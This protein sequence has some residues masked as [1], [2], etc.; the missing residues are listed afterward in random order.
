MTSQPWPEKLPAQSVRIARPT[1]RLDDVVRFYTRRA[2]AA[3]AR[4]FRRSCRLPGRAAGVARLGTTW[5]SPSMITAARAGA[6][7]DNLLV[8]YFGDLAQVGQVARRLAALGHLPVEAEN[9]YWT[10]NGAVTVEDP[11]GWRV[12]LMP[13]PPDCPADGGPVIRLGVPADLPAASDVYR[14]ASLSNAG[15]RDNLLAHQEHLVLGPEG[16]AEGRTYVA[17]GGRV[18]CRLRYPEPR[19]A[20]YFRAGRPVRRSRLATARDC[21]RARGPHC[22]CSACAGRGA[23]GGDGQPGRAG[24]LPRCRFHQLWHCRH[25]LRRRTAHGAGNPLPGAG[26]HMPGRFVRTSA[27][28]TDSATASVPKP[29]AIEAPVPAG[30]SWC[31]MSSSRSQLCWPIVSGM[32]QPS[33]TSSGSENG[34]AAAPRAHRRGLAAR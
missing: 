6:Q 34:G 16:L 21:R 30:A 15:D 23:P 20:A 22:A 5:S 25:R 1:D 7:P 27:C 2:R 8:L 10:E 33:S 9:P 26:A 18:A 24:V 3:R 12:V 14:R 28:R 13:R 17:V 19:A 31:S 32:K 29:I 4:P 11:D